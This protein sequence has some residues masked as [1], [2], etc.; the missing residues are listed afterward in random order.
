MYFEEN[1]YKTHEQKIRSYLKIR[2][3]I[4]KLLLKEINNH[5]QEKA[6]SEYILRLYNKQS[7]IESSLKYLDII[8]VTDYLS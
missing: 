8:K 5:E 6:I 1:N 7:D 3:R 4:E 2:K